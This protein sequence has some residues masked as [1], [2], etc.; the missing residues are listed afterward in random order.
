MDRGK[1]GLAL[2]PGR[3]YFR[4]VQMYY[5]PASVRLRQYE[6]S[7]IEQSGPVVQ[8]ESRNRTIAEHLNLHVLWLNVHIRRCLFPSA[9][10]LEH[11]FESLLK[12]SAPG[13]TSLSLSDI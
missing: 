8:M 13:E 1:Y 7:P 12:F 9:N 6:R 5:F 2:W 10:L 11:N 4:S 3:E